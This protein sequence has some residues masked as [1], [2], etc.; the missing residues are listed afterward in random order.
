[1]IIFIIFVEKFNKKK[2]FK[3]NIIKIL[4]KY[5]ITIIEFRKFEKLFTTYAS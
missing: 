2:Q 4:N 5:A 1:M 3:T